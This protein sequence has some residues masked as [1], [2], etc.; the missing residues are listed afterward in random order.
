VRAF[1]YLTATV[2]AAIAIG[3]GVSASSWSAP[4]SGPPVPSA[5]SHEYGPP[6]YRFEASFPGKVA[7]VPGIFRTRQCLSGKRGVDTFLVDVYKFDAEPAKY[8][9]SGP[10]VNA[11]GKTVRFGRVHGVVAPVRCTEVGQISHVQQQCSA[12]MIVTDGVTVWD[13]VTAETFATVNTRPMTEFLD[14]F[15]PIES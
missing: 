2:L 12:A 5:V 11:R 1:V 6:G 8:R 9:P 14:S 4:V 13:V 10:L 3:V 15:R 7:C